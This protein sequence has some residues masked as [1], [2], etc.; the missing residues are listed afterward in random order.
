VIKFAINRPIATS[1]TYL[2]IALL[3]YQAWRN[4]PVEDLPDTQLPKLSVKA[5]WQGASP[6]TMEAFVTSPLEAAIQQVQGVDSVASTSEF[7]KGSATTKID[8]VFERETDME[9]ARLE[10]SQRL[11]VV[12][13]D[14]L[15]RDVRTELD[16]YVPRE[17]D[18]QFQQY[19]GILQYTLTGPLTEEALARFAD[20]KLRPEL[21]RVRG[22]AR[23]DITGLQ[24]RVLSLELS[25]NAL[26]AFRVSSADV[27]RALYDLHRQRSIGSVASE[28][29][30]RS[31]AVRDEPASVTGVL[32]APV[33][34]NG[35][36]VVRI[37]DVAT[38]RSTYQPPS[39][40]YRVNRNPA[41]SITLEPARGVDVVAVADSAR[42]KLNYL[43]TILPTGSRLILDNDNTQRIR[44]NFADLKLRSFLS[45]IIIFAVLLLFLHSF[46]S[47]VIVFATI[48]F[49]LLVSLN[50]MYW[51]DHSLN[52]LSLM[53]LAMG[54]GLVVDDAIVV[55]ENIYR[56]W[57]EG[58]APRAASDR[59]AH[60]VVVAV[61]ASTLTTVIVFIPFMYLQGEARLFYVPFAVAVASSLIAS[62]F[63]SFSFI[64]ALATR[65]LASRHRMEAPA[66][67]LLD[68]A[69]RDKQPLY[70]RLYAG[71]VRGT[72]RWPWATVFCATM[73]LG[74]SYYL[75]RNYV[76]FSWGNW[77]TNR[78]AQAVDMT[79]QFTGTED[80]NYIDNIA[81]DIERQLATFPGVT[82][83]TTNVSKDAGIRIHVTFPDSM[84]DSYV[85]YAVKDFLSSMGPRLGAAET[86]QVYGPGQPFFMGGGGGNWAQVQIEVFGYNYRR[87]REIAEE[88]GRI[89]A[90]F[91]RVKN[92][93]IEGQVL[94]PEMVVN[95]DRQRLA[96]H[97]IT[98]ADASSVIQQATQGETS[99]PEISLAGE[100]VQVMQKLEGYDKM[101]VHELEQ[102]LIRTP[103]GTDVRLGDVAT[104]T[105]KPTMGSIK[106]ENQQYRRGIAYDVF[107]TPKYAT[108]TQKAVLNAV[109]VPDGYRVAA[110]EFGYTPPEQKQLFRVLGLALLLVF[111]ITAAL[112]ESV[113]QPLCVMLTVPM[114]L[115]GV[116][117]LFF[118]KGVSFD[119]NSLIGV[120]MM[121]GIVV[122]NAILLVDRVNQVRETGRPLNDAIVL[123][124]LQRVRPI[125]MTSIVTIMGVLPFVLFGKVS[126][127]TEW[128]AM[129]YAL[130]GGLSS[131]TIL[132]LVVTPSLYLLF[133]RRRERRRLERLAR[134]QQQVPP[135]VPA[136]ETA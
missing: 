45:A 34:T 62:L 109:T 7:S 111:M 12:A 8:I 76:N 74:G 117:L 121:S 39:N 78:G 63:V 69:S 59:G 77:W 98:V 75:F 83:F 17:F 90:R 120:I 33:K 24:R 61:I 66:S 132:V 57:R 1:M 107:G 10:L 20:D 60:E 46:R 114:A 135:I 128:E 81:Q 122:K 84:A 131:S 26:A 88:V 55:L 97:G 67:T 14:Q 82:H 73:L 96:N 93:N 126:R 72:L 47:A 52:S 86:V 21:L 64:P 16:Q 50:V 101:D 48:F 43:R 134:Q 31:L 6:Q 42:E 94:V 119:E 80:L 99:A 130:I 51:S 38:A 123:G 58:D 32:N 85:P 103:G 124:T 37:K 30:M 108:R 102:L 65:L 106:R 92:I 116:F 79:V 110:A 129:S 70:L 3:G 105:L 100:R 13:R 2:A 95:F 112:F 118:Y 87:V 136:P 91:P 19:Q 68:S 133:E 23:V 44:E 113:R 115:I 9:F 28:G 41:V 53:G 29:L 11:A 25:P 127:M 27:N 40:L 18:P 125:L 5:T 89:L 15:P 56:R 35:P 4:I 104:I 22:V 54:F 36:R 49:S 71:V